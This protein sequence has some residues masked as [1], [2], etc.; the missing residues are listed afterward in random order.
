[1]AT[2]KS[3]LAA[4]EQAHDALL[5]TIWIYV[6]YDDPNANANAEAEQLAQISAAKTKG[7]R[8]L[9]SPGYILCPAQAESVEAWAA[10]MAAEKAAHD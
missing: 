5:E 2:I 8:V 4:L 9:Y 10:Q 7:Q 6:R 3:R 1:M